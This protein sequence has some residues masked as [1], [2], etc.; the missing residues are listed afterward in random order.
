M[1]VHDSKIIFSHPLEDKKMYI[2][3]NQT[4]QVAY[5]TEHR[6]KSFPAKLYSID[7]FTAMTPNFSRCSDTET[8][9]YN[10][11]FTLEYVKTKFVTE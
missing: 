2:I 1:C 3:L 7:S 11:V 8:N 5:R 4:M 6:D 10:S 9:L